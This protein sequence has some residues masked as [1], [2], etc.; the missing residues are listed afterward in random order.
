VAQT[1][2]G[3]NRLLK[4]LTPSDLS[5]LEPRLKRSSLVLGKTLSAPG[6]EI[7]HVYFPVSGMVSLLTVM[8][9]GES[10]ETAIIGKEGVVGAS[11]GSDGSQSTNQATVQIS[12]MAWQVEGRQFLDLYQSSPTFRQLINRFQNI[13]LIQAQ[14]SAACHA[15]HSVEARLCRWLLQSQDTTE[16]DSVPL[17][18]EFL[19]HMLGVRRT[20][21]SMCAH[22]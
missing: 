21:V 22:G 11:I 7:E 17:T 16:S 20:T 6:E 1:T 9:T 12:G 3:E 5:Y 13:V 4:A 15:L 8:R 18:Q 2:I 19:S 14:Q 10:I